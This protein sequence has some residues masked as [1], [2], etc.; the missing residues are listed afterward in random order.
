MRA[1]RNAHV[2]FLRCPRTHAVKYVG[3]SV[4]PTARLAQHMNGQ[5][6]ATRD[7]VA[8]LGECPVL[9]VVFSGVQRNQAERIEARLQMFH[10]ALNLDFLPVSGRLWATAHNTPRS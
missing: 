5:C 9:D 1:R 4:N 3:V 7:W 2:Y 6:K 10:R 8:Q